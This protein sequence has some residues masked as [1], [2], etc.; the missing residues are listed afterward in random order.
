MSAGRLVAERVG[1]A[2]RRIFFLLRAPSGACQRCVLIVPP[3]AEEMNKSR[4]MMS[5]AAQAL[6]QRGVA[7]ATFDLPGT[8]DSDG[9]FGEVTWDDWVSSIA[10]VRRRCAGK[11]LPVTDLLGIRLGCILGA[12]FLRQEGVKLESMLCWQPVHD[13]G[14][15]LDQFLRLRTAASMASGF[16]R[17]T[18]KDLRQ[19]LSNGDALEIAGYRLAPALAE[20]MESAR[21]AVDDS[22]LR[23]LSWADVVAADIESPVPA[24]TVRII[25]GIRSAGVEVDYRRM[26]GEPFWSSTEIVVVPELIR[27]T[28]AAMGSEV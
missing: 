11:G 16:A 4:R 28:L 18:V 15:A 27:Y 8:G 23:H 19:R 21:L 2:G 13:G 5:L 24:Q 12:E 6:S 7:V 22:S 10:E 20:R 3:F 14:R 17:E 9:E 25:E 26:A 1:E